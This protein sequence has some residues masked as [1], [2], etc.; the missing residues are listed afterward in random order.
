MKFWILPPY[1]LK[2]IIHGLSRSGA[3]FNVILFRCPVQ[4]E[5]IF[6]FPFDFKEFRYSQFSHFS[7]L[8]DR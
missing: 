3:L 8:L 2:R 7:I 5:S 4:V 6:N 1:L